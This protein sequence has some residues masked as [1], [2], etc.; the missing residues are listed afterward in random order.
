MPRKTKDSSLP[1]PYKR[2]FYVSSDGPSSGSLTLTVH[3]SLF[4]E[5]SSSLETSN[6]CFSRLGCEGSYVLCAFDGTIDKVC[7]TYGKTK[8]VLKAQCH[9]LSDVI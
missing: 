5:G 3:Y 6:F 2:T 4:D 1:K 7:L 8:H 9:P